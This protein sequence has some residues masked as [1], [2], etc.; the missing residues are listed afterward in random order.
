MVAR[1]GQRRAEPVSAGES[2]G[3]GQ[4]SGAASRNSSAQGERNARDGP[5]GVRKPRRA[6]L[7]PGDLGHAK[8]LSTLL[9]PTSSAGPVLSQACPE[10]S[11]R[12]DGTELTA[13]GEMVRVCGREE[14]ERLLKTFRVEV[15]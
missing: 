13:L 3:K 1:K 7:F 5:L 11:R 4:D 2:H 6:A 9:W 8:A 12:V 15:R 10:P 14:A